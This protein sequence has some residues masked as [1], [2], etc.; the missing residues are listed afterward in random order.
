MAFNFTV[1]YDACVL[2]PAHL[3]DLLMQLALSD[4][5]RARWTEQIH[6]EWIRNV[7]KNRSD[8]PF[9]QLSRTKKLMNSNVR[10]CLVT[11]Y[12]YLIF[13]LQLPDLDD[14]H[15]LAAAIAGGAEAIVTFN[16]SDFPQSILDQYNVV[17]QHPDNFISDLLDLKPSKVVAAAK[18]CQQR[19]K[20]PPKSF[21]EYL[22]ILLKQ[23]LSVS[24]SMFQELYEET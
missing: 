6:D 8:L 2:Y 11:N 21:G 1:I 16:L 23:G 3:R 5:F 20:N 4:L 9:E 19:L 14:R 7:L 17:A 15:V 13:Q 24:V 22:E 12:E 18:T 10:D